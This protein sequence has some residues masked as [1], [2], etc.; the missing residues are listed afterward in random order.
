MV[1]LPSESVWDY[2]RPPLVEPVTVELRVEFNGH[3]IGRTTAGYRVCETS[4]APAY[5]FPPDD[6]GRSYLELNS[7]ASYCEWKGLAGYYDVLAGDR[8]SERAAWYYADPPKLFAAITNYVAFYA[9]AMDV[10]FVGM[11]AVS[12]MDGDFYGGWITPN[13]VGPIKGAPGTQ[14]W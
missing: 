14:H 1:E 11:Q 12:P 13:L 10:C 4:H 6:V 3:V 2:P 8:R 5:Y 7:E 9:G